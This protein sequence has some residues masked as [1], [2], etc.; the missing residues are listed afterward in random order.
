M[1]YPIVIHKETKSDFGVTVPDLPGCFSAGTTFE[2][3]LENAVEAIECHVE[4]LLKDGEAV[5]N[6]YPI[7]HYQGKRQ[8]RGGVWALVN[9]DLTKLSG[10]AKRINITLPE[11]LLSQLDQYAS[12]HDQS[13]SGLIAQAALEYLSHQQ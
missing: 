6:P 2:E 1:Q 9:V 11:Y 10:K 5:T 3:A 7:D 13:R 4:A 8:Y 12:R